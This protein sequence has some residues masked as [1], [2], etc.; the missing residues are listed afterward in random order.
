M[1]NPNLA[2]GISDIRIRIGYG[3]V[4]P[5][6]PV[7]TI[8]MLSTTSADEDYVTKVVNLTFTLDASATESKIIYLTRD[9]LP[10]FTEAGKI[11]EVE[12]FPGNSVCVFDKERPFYLYEDEILSV[13]FLGQ[14]GS[15]TPTF[16]IATE[17]Y[18]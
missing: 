7:G 9:N 11:C 10:G 15:G 5:S 2:E 6:S 13:E 16:Y 8:R 4:S 12:V 3:A 14:T 18:S 1:S 17:E